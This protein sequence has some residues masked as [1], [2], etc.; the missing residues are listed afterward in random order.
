MSNA[1]IL[2]IDEAGTNAPDISTQ[3]LED[4]CALAEGFEIPFL[5]L[6][7]QNNELALNDALRE[8]IASLNKHVIVICGGHLESAVTQI[9]LSGL[10]DGYDIFVVADLSL[11]SDQQH[12]TVF[13]D[14]LRSC[15]AHIVTRKQ[16]VFEAIAQNTEKGAVPRLHAL[17]DP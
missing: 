9:T 15:G 5:K 14:R 1:A 8:R 6:G 13:F 4:A 16:L 3:Y 11:S 7:P 12:E 10:L 17:L 2:Y